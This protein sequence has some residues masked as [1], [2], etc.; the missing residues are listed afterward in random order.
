MPKGFSAY[1]RRSHEHARKAN[2]DTQLGDPA[3]LCGIAGMGEPMIR[4]RFLQSLAGAVLACKMALP[5]GA[6]HLELSQPEDVLTAQKIRNFVSKL[7]LASY[8][9][10]ITAYVHPEQYDKWAESFGLP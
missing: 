7:K 8:N 6:V 2:A 1:Q 3:R 9:D 4:R 10:E 5:L